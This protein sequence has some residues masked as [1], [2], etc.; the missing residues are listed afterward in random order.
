MLVCLTLMHVCLTL[1][2]V[3]PTPVAKPLVRMLRSLGGGVALAALGADCC[4][5]AGKVLQDAA[6]ASAC[7]RVVLVQVSA[8]VLLICRVH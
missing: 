3:R 4:A 2:H 5:L 8:S 1:M 7:G 6:V